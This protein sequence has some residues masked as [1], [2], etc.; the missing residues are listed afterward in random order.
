MEVI[1]SCELCQHVC[2]LFD[3]FFVLF[4]LFESQKSF[5]RIQPHSTLT[6]I[7]VTNALQQKNYLEKLLSKD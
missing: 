4:I 1:P 5:E 7:F 3:R 6:S 2:D